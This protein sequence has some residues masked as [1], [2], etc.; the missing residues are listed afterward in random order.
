VIIDLD[1]ADLALAS[2]S[3]PATVETPNVHALIKERDGLVLLGL[4]GTADFV[5]LMRDAMAAH[6]R[7]DPILGKTPDSFAADAEQILWRIFSRFNGPWVG[8]GHSKG[9]SEILDVAAMM[10]VIGRPALRIGAFE[11]APTGLLGGYID[12]ATTLITWHGKDPVPAAPPWRRHP[13]AVT[14]LPWRGAEPI[15]PL[16]Y[17]SMAGVRAAMAA[18]A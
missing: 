9:G 16:D 17:H 18:A 12:P 7:D 14:H 13:V 11:P 3:E 8:G 4:R 10:R 15:N 1:L 5:A 2:Y 6:E